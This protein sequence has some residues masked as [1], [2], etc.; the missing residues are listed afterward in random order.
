M[1]VLEIKNLSKKFGDLT[2]CNNISFDLKEKEIFGIAGP[3][4]AGKTTLFNCLAGLYKNT[5]KIIFNG[6]NIS[7]LNSDQVCHIGIARTM[8]I[9]TIFNS[10]TVRENIE[11]GAYFGRGMKNFKNEIREIIDFLNIKDIVA[12]RG[13]SLNLYDKKL[14]MIACA[15]ATK[16]EIL[17]LD[18]PMGG[19]SPTEIEESMDT[20]KKINSEFGITIIIIEH[21]MKVITGISNRLLILDNGSIVKIGDPFEVCKDKKVIKVY[22]GTVVEHVKSK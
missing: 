1:N 12:K 22:L 4:G 16:P 13:E 2:A 8:Q 17:L 11:V 15:L 10:M 21:L 6:K 20:V 18:E 9:P 3:N 14:T 19:L 7:N 5:G